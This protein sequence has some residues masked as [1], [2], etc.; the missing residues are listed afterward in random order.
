M[1]FF[2]LLILLGI[3]AVV[4]FKKKQDVDKETEA[5]QKSIEAQESFDRSCQELQ[6]DLD[7]M[8]REL[9]EALRQ[10]YDAWEQRFCSEENPGYKISG[11]NFQNLTEKQTGAFKGTVVHEDW[12]AFDPDAVA[13]YRG[14]KKVGYIP[15]EFSKDVR[16]RISSTKGK[17]EC[18]GCIY[19]WYKWE[20]GKDSE[21]IFAGKVIFGP[22]QI[23]DSSQVN[24]V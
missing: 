8:H 19:M 17:L 10:E 4:V 1:G 15:K 21:T 9:N 3:I 20:P 6:E 7:K 16:E 12:N 24:S 2:L 18:Y 23:G 14:K 13:I 22:S 5:H 11:I